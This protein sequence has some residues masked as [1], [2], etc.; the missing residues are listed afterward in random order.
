MLDQSKL[1]ALSACM[2]RYL[3]RERIVVPPLE[4]T[5]LVSCSLV[6]NPYYTRDSDIAPLEAE[7]PSKSMLLILLRYFERFT[8]LP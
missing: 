6:S 1:H 5:K 4:G 8:A 2:K 3:I 7:H